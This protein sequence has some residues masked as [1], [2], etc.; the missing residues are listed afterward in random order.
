MKKVTELSHPLIKHKLSL[1]RDKTTDTAKFRALC[2]EIAMLMAYEVSTELVLHHRTIETPIA[3]TQAP[4]ID[5]SQIVLVSILRAG[6]ALLEGMLSLLPAAKVGHIGLYR[7]PDTL[8]AVEYY[9]K[10]PAEV[11]GK[12]IIVVDPMLATGHTSVAAV[13]RLKKAQPR[14]IKFINLLAAPE[15]L[16]LFHENHPDV[17]VITACIDSHLNEKSY[18]VPGLGDAG[19][20]FYGTI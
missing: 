6:N 5:E 15:G 20:R 18:I 1:M 9:C 8:I 4:F 17:E 13:L 11:G 12:D 10:L 16:D 7:D 19:D 3:V 2:H 14:S